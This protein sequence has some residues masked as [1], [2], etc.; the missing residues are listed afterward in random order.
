MTEEPQA[1]YP[2]PNDER[3]S[4]E[5]IPRDPMLFKRWADVACVEWPLDLT[6]KAYRANEALLERGVFDPVDIDRF[7][8][9]YFEWWSRSELKKYQAMSDDQQ[10]N[11][12]RDNKRRVA[13]AIA[14]EYVPCR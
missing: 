10:H 4:P 8:H 13:R 11:R 14:A 6:A 12:Y 1:L 9:A 5:E 2:P 7:R 3:M